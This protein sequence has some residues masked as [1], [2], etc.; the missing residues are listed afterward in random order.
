[1]INSLLK[2]LV[3]RGVRTCWKNFIIQFDSNNNAT[4]TLNRGLILFLPQQICKT[5]TLHLGAWKKQETN[6]AIL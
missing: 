5:K 2:V 3:M 1:M 4:I 6:G